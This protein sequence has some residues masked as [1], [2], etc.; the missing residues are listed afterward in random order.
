MEK[1]ILIK[2]KEVAVKTWNWLK[3]KKTNIYAIVQSGLI[4]AHWISPNMIPGDTYAEAQK[5]ITVFGIFAI[6]DKARRNEQLKKWMENLSGK[7]K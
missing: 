7:L 5:I 1:G 6:G 4:I 2:A 3:G